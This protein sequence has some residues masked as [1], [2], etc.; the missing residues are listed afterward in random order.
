MS[1]F[2]KTLKEL[3]Y[4][5]NSIQNALGV[6]AITETRIIKNKRAAN[7]NLTNHSYEYCPTASSVWVSVLCTG[8]HLL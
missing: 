3:E 8:S 7:D 1:S 2:K 4:H 5:L 6:V